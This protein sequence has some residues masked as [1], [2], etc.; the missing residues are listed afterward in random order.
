MPGLKC[1]LCSRPFMIR[2]WRCFSCVFPPLCSPGC[3]NSRWPRLIFAAIRIPGSGAK[4]REAAVWLLFLIVRQGR[5]IICKL[6]ESFLRV[7]SVG[8]GEEGR[9][10]GL[11][12]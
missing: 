10:W 12:R 6:A 3:A 1:Q 4:G 9:S 7:F 2:K 11:R 8:C 5:E